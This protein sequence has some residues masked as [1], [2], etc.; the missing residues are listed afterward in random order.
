MRE[1]AG[2]HPCPLRTEPSR[3]G[4]RPCGLAWGTPLLAWTSQ[5]GGLRDAAGTGLVPRGGTR[6]GLEQ[7]LPTRLG[8]PAY[9]LL[10]PPDSSFQPHLAMPL[11]TEQTQEEPGRKGSVGRTDSTGHC[12][13]FLQKKKQTARG[14]SEPGSGPT[15]GAPARRLPLQA[16]VS[17]TVKWDPQPWREGCVSP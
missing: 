15:A 3:E 1:A 12:L 10:S 5:A 13:P 7:P 17:S 9:T 8:C 16:P 14:F 11:T 6:R 2:Q 4:L